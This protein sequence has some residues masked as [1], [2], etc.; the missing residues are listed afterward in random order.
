MV[1]ITAKGSRLAFGLATGLAKRLLAEPACAEGLE[2]KGPSH[3]PCGNPPPRKTPSIEVFIPDRFLGVIPEPVEGM[4]DMVTVRGVG[5]RESAARESVASGPPSAL[6]ALFHEL[7]RYDG[8]ICVMAVGI[9]V[10]LIAPHLRNKAT[11]PAVVV[12]DEGGRWSISLVSG[13]FGRA[14]DL[15]RLVAQVSGGEAVITTASDLAGLP[16]FDTLARDMGWIPEPMDA[17]RRVAAS[18]VNG[19]RVDVYTDY[20]PAHLRRL[21][22]E[23][24]ACMGGVRVYGLSQWSGEQGGAAALVFVTN[25]CLPVMGEA[26]AR[27]LS[28]TPVLFLRP[29]NVVAGVGCRK[30][31]AVELIVE[32]VEKALAAAGIALSSL[33]ALATTDF[34][35]GEPGIRSAAQHLGVPLVTV[36]R[37]EVESLERNGGFA[38]SQLV[39]QRVGVGGVCEPAAILGGAYLNNARPVARLV[40]P[41]TVFPQTPGVTVALAVEQDDLSW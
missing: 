19:Q 37:E 28:A 29:R 4:T 10:R 21:L 24:A 38:P 13:H 32:A 5:S 11:D 27:G 20:D 7:F 40:L 1:A 6:R 14:N 31:T 17:L 12:I 8:V 25:R 3:G 15:A 35:G 18:V 33:K 34:K 39:R 22:E 36:G 2:S 9:V 16:A 23:R 30:G 26:Q 41:K